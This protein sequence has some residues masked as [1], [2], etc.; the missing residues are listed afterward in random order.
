MKVLHT[1]DWHLGR[2]FHGHGLHA[3]HAA[4]LSWLLGVAVEHEVDAVLVAGDV[5]DRSVPP[6]DSVRLLDA[7]LE[8]FAARG[9]PVVLISGNHDNPTRLGFGRAFAAS[10]GI[11]L[12]TSVAQLGEPVLLTDDHGVVG[13]Y[14]IPYLSPDL[15]RDQLEAERSHAAVLAAAMHRIR[16]DAQR[17]GLHRT[18]VL[19]HAFVAGGTSCESERSIEVGGVAHAPASVFSGVSYVALGHLHGSQEVR[20]ADSATVLA[21]AGSPLTFSFSEADHTKSVTVVELDAEGVAGRKEI[22]VPV[23]RRAVVLRG[24]VE[25]L[26][27][28]AA[29]HPD[30]YRDVFVKAVVTDRRWEPGLYDR[31]R[32]AW[33]LLERIE[34]A[35]EQHRDPDHDLARLRRALVDPAQVCAMFVEYVGGV[36]PVDAE[37]SVLRRAVER[38]F[39]A[40]GGRD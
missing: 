25:E 18:V 8:A 29:A 11:H 6:V 12:F 1:S 16:V 38:V 14:G 21:Y 30:R 17:R 36:P 13:V 5:Y 9:I 3:D 32:A 4:F 34:L 28:L 20:L 39:A 10:A 15:V 37:A 35:G 27:G 7:T 19:A 40:D 23:G 2:T 24:S 33:P 22:P 31:L 26:T